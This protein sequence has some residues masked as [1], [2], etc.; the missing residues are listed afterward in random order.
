V[1]EAISDAEVRAVAEALGDGADSFW[2]PIVYPWSVQHFEPRPLAERPKPPRDGLRLY[3]HI[4]FCRYHCTFC[5]YAVRGGARR[6][7]MERY[8]AALARELEAVEPGTSLSK[9]IVGGGTP[10]ALPPDL[11]DA[12]LAPIIARTQRPA[13]CLSKVE[14]SP[15]SLS[16]E[17]IAVLHK[18]GIRWMSIGVES[19]DE[20]VL[21]TVRRRHSTAQAMDALRRVAKSGLLL[22]ADLIYG[23]PGQSFASFRRDL[24]QIIE[25]GVDS[26][27]MYGLRLNEK[28]KVTAQLREAERLDLARVMRWRAFV[29]RTAG[30]LGFVQTRTYIWK[31]RDGARPAPEGERRQTAEARGGLQELALGMS[32]RSQLAGTVYRNHERFDVY[33]DRVERG[34]SPVESVFELDALDQRTQ[35]VAGTL[36]NGKPLVRAAYQRRFGA[37]IDAHYGELLGR[38]RGAGLIDDDGARLRLSELGLLVYDRLLQCFYPPR[39]QQWLRDGVGA[40]P[41]AA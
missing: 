37:E 25:A 30:E 33:L 23:L 1:T 12:V 31:R 22:N 15:D 2:T 21:G 20:A 35:F 8:V 16:D 36:G 19:T 14:A 10:T 4:P 34:R 29:A 39:A 9:L 24:E 38:L 26:V 6:L 28:T 11:L 41:P 17:H 32:A 5:I 7:E 18:H 40:P 13:G 3:V 27:C